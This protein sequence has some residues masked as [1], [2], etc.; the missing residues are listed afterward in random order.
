MD[1][2]ERGAYPPEVVS[3]NESSDSS[4]TRRLS[5]CLCGFEAH[6]HLSTQVPALDIKIFLLTFIYEAIC[7]RLR[8]YPTE[9]FRAPES[10]R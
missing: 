5:E 9:R 10:I 7:F 3:A 2:R 8:I 6:H 4:S 1:G